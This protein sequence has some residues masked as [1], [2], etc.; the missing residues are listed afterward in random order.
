MNRDFFRSYLADYVEPWATQ[1]VGPAFEGNAGAAFSLV[2]TASNS[3]RTQT[4]SQVARCLPT[5]VYYVKEALN[6][7]T[8]AQAATFSFCP[9]FSTI[10]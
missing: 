1:Y 6:G 10:E 8:T 7:L 9:R 3:K 4:C 5:T 2:V